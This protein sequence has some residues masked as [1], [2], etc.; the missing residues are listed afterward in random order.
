MKKLTGKS[1]NNLKEVN[2]P[3]TNMISKLES[4]KRGEDKYRTLKMHLKLRDQKSETILPKD[5]PYIQNIRLL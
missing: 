1:K 2:H 5:I 4:M 3:M